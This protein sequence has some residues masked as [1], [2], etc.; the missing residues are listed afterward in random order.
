M[1]ASK[2]KD[3]TEVSPVHPQTSTLH[4]SPAYCAVSRQLHTTGL[5]LW[6]SV[7]MTLCIRDANKHTYDVNML[8]LSCSPMIVSH[9]WSTFQGTISPMLHPWL[10]KIFSAQFG[11]DSTHMDG[12]VFRA[13]FGHDSTHGWWSFSG[14]NL[15][16]LHPRM[17]K[18][19]KAKCSHDW[20]LHKYIIV[21]KCLSDAVQVLLRLGHRFEP[22]SYISLSSL[23]SDC[24]IWESLPRCSFRELENLA[25]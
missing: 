23:G 20:C 24:H 13:Q 15:A 7:W 1:E 21:M 17:V 11:H 4:W 18:F 22:A 10:V 6:W 12:Q 5:I 19:F 3:V 8:H 9:W 14:H 25:V 16:W 2:K